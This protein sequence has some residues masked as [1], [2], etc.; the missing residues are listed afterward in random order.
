MIIA[1]T[2]LSQLLHRWS[3]ENPY[4]SVTAAAAIVYAT[5][6]LA[7]RQRSKTTVD[8][9]LVPSLVP[10]GV[11]FFGHMLALSKDPEGF[12]NKATA[13]YGNAFRIRIPG[14]DPYV[15]CGP[16][17]AEVLTSSTRLLSFND[18]IQTVVPMYR[19]IHTCYDHKFIG[20][21]TSP[22]EK[23]PV[24]YPI[25]Q[26][27]KP[28]LLGVFTERM[29]TAFLNYLNKEI[30]LAPNEQRT[31][32]VWRFFTRGVSHV[33]CP[34]F[35]G[36]KVG[37]DQELIESMAVFT[38]KIVKA[39]LMLSFFPTWLGN[40]V[41]K[42]FYSVEGELD[43]IMKLLLP[44]L[45]RMRN[46]PDHVNDEVSFATMTLNMRKSDGSLRTPEDAAF[47]FKDIALASI[48][49]TS[50]F[51][52]FALHELACRPE[53]VRA[54][55]QELAKLDVRTP[56]N[57]GAI[58]LMDSFMRETLRWNG[59][60]LGLHHLALQDVALSN[61]QVIPKGS[62]VV[63]S[64]DQIHRGDYLG[65]S[66]MEN[67]DTKPAW[68]FDPY[69]YVHDDKP[70]AVPDTGYIAFGLGAHACPGRYFAVKEIK[71]M[72][73][74]IV[75]RFDLKTQ[76]GQRAKDVIAF[77]MNRFPPTEPIIFTGISTPSTS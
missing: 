14:Q 22:R 40:F 61:G 60:Y 73:G 10:G 30:V 70:S 19:V 1:D 12:I 59:D 28:H 45:R 49:T 50:H 62:L 65:M 76:S 66:S 51:A 58:P 37:N 43:L 3:K 20:E 71:Y 34:C 69:R 57:V 44:E 23:N 75:M 68:V 21:G 24:S 33:S 35:A 67:K 72:M 29:Q 46:N 5:W 55:R 9:A 7:R 56:E 16:L 15:V 8:S 25:K 48:H 27:F 39:G 52:T 74:E 31:V 77:G 2:R 64:V 11:P 36:S 18:G 4:L 26:N 47:W 41:V 42:R 6:K 38:Q 54:L 53:L 13:D 63:L 17:V 32:D